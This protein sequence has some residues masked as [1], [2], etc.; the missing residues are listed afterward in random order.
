MNL[1]LEFKVV[2]IASVLN[3]VA[4][5]TKKVIMKKIVYFL[6]YRFKIGEKLNMSEQLL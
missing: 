2:W 6:N 3:C 4:I 5:G 1:E